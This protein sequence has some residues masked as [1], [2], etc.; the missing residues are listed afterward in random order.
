MA[1]AFFNCS[2]ISKKNTGIGETA[3]QL[4]KN[5]HCSEILFLSPIEVE[6]KNVIKIPENLSPNN[7][8]FT[9]I[10]R[11]FWVQFQV[12]K[13]MRTYK[14][15]TFISP[16][17]EA[18]LFS[19]FKNIVFVH[20][21]IPLRFPKFSFIFL[22]HLFYIPLVLHQSKIILCNS[23]STARDVNK[24]YRI[25]LKKIKVIKLGF[26][27]NLYYPRNRIR[28]KFFLV[29]GRHNPYKNLA[30]LLKAFE[31]FNNKHYKIIFIGPCDKRFT[32]KLKKLAK[33]L[34]IDSQCEWR[35]WVS[36]EEKL[37]LLN[38]CKGLYIISLWEGFGLPALEAMACGTR[39]VIS[40]KGGLPEIGSGIGAIVDPKDIKQ[41]TNT[42]KEISLENQLSNEYQKKGL[43]RSKEYSWKSA[44]E[45]IE[46]LII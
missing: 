35:D 39:F 34:N 21:L 45:E 29:I 10:R 26:D 9:H 18:P 22:Y 36:V 4:M 30:R 27:N 20:D 37:N 33:K 2:Y 41:I 5:I 44:A 7:N 31:K 3:L 14:V 23:K 8:V 43:L 42:M 19:G 15:D 17:P 6:E 11:L 25:P 32:P 12:P 24:I 16:L 28:E 38:T 40:N 46:N 1:K 13:L